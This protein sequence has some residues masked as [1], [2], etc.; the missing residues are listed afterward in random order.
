[1][2]S[3]GFPITPDPG[4]GTCVDFTPCGGDPVGDWLID[5]LC[6]TPLPP[7]LNAFCPAVV[8]T[9]HITGTLSLGA[10]GS[11]TTAPIVN[12][13]EVVPSSCVPELGGC[14]AS[15]GQLSR[16]TP[17][18]DGS[19]ICDTTNHQTPDTSGRFVAS[20]DHLWLVDAAAPSAVSDTYYFC[21]MGNRLLMRGLNEGELFV[22]QLTRK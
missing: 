6:I 20:D 12:V 22:Y 8:E 14:G 5:D 11:V 17:E 19:C 9:V 15:A 16:C 4:S 1:M 13:H 2:G 21:Q 18:A 3:A 10:D 7:G